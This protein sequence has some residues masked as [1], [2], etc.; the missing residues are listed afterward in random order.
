MAGSGGFIDA[1]TEPAQASAGSTGTAADPCGRPGGLCSGLGAVSTFQQQPLGDGALL[2]GGGANAVER[3]A[4]APLA[5]GAALS[6][7]HGAGAA[8]V[9][10]LGTR[11]HAAAAR[12]RGGG[13]CGGVGPACGP[14]AADQRPVHH[15]SCGCRRG[16]SRLAAL[17]APSRS[18][19]TA[20]T[21]HGGRL[22]SPPAAAACSPDW[23]RG[24]FVPNR[25]P[26]Q[27]HPG[28]WR[29][30]YGVGRKILASGHVSGIPDPAT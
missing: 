4:G 16:E 25:W 12:P 13:R 26:A 24:H 28:P 23:L 6:T 29:R 27:R 15:R 2:V 22:R 30:L 10:A 14:G 11:R 19:R 8:S 3:A 5:R 18:S 7:A 21:S 1:Q 17:Q 9:P 20:D